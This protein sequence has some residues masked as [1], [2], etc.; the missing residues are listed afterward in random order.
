VK[1]QF[2]PIDHARRAR[3]QLAN[4][5]QTGSVYGYVHTFRRLL[6]QCEDVSEAE[7]LDRF[8]RGLKMGAVK[9]FV[10]LSQCST[11]NDAAVIAERVASTG[12]NYSGA[13][14]SR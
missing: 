2:R 10:Q 12:N 4:C 5:T 7:S 8:Q 11:F 3:D 13:S 9:Q 14:T 6:I 1:E